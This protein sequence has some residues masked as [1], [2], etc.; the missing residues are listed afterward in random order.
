MILRKGMW[1][2][3]KGRVGIL[4]GIAATSG[5]VH[6]VDDKGVTVERADVSLRALTQAAYDDIPEARR[7]DE[8]TAKRLRYLPDPDAQGWE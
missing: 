5:E 6:Y 2:T 4:A 1:V 7:P 8:A 3:V